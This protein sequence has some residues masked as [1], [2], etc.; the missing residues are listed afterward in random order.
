MISI[1]YNLRGVL[2]RRATSLMTIMGV[3]MVA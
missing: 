1:R 2:E 3:G